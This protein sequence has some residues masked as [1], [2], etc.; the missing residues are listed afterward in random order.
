[1]YITARMPSSVTIGLITGQFVTRLTRLRGKRSNDAKN[2]GRLE[3]GH[4]QRVLQ[5][6]ERRFQM[7]WLSSSHIRDAV[8]HSEVSSILKNRQKRKLK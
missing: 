6:T 3:G 2:Q 7:E 5:N 1:M 4:V 8:C